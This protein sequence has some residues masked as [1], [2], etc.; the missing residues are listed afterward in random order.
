MNFFLII[1]VNIYLSESKSLEDIGGQRRDLNM[2]V[3]GIEK[4]QRNIES[5]YQK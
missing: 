4:T 5:I 1:T 2:S 3:K